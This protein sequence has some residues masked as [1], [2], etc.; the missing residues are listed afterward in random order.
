MQP[1]DIGTVTDRL[2]LAADE[3]PVGGDVLG[4]FEEKLTCG[5]DLQVSPVAGEELGSD[6]A[7]DALDLLAHRGLA[8][9]ELSSGSADRSRVHHGGEDL[10]QLH[11]HDVP[12]LRVVN[13]AG[14]PCGSE[15]AG[16]SAAYPQRV[17]AGCE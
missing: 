4:M 10:Q 15:P 9:A 14:P 1:A 7:L 13:G 12:I 17:P 16:V 6:L 5:G 8:E 11:V 3:S 2:D